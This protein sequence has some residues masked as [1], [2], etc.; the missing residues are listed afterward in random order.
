MTNPPYL[1]ASTH[2]VLDAALQLAYS[3]EH[4]NSAIPRVGYN[5]GVQPMA[6]KITASVKAATRKDDQTGVYVS[7][8]PALRLHSQGTDE[9]RAR[10]AI[11]SAIMLFLSTCIKHGRL[12]EAL[13]DRGFESMAMTEDAKSPQEA[14]KEFITLENANYED[15]FEINVPLYLL[16]ERDKEHVAC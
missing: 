10:A 16:N 8:C 4:Q 13:Q 14:M 1:M 6:L 5:Q 3:C 12:D 11:R 7:Y 2:G 15:V 9:K